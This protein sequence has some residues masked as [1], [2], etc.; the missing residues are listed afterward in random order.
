MPEGSHVFRL[1]ADDPSPL[2]AQGKSLAELKM[3][4]TNRMNEAIRLQRERM[5]SL[6]SDVDSKIVSLKKEHGVREGAA[7]DNADGGLQAGLA[8]TKEVNQSGIL[9]VFP[10]LTFDSDNKEND[11]RSSSFVGLHASAYDVN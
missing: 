1:E 2:D 8:Q 10:A 6:L 7:G 3:S 5:Q 9:P 4:F 11:I